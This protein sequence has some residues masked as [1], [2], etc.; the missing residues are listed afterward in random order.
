[1]LPPGYTVLG[2]LDD[3]PSGPVTVAR[4][5]HGGPA[6]AV[7][8]LPSPGDPALAERLGLLLDLRHPGAAT[9]LDW[10]LADDGLT[11]VSELL[12]AVPLRAL[13]ERSGLLPA[14]AAMV[15]LQDSLVAIAA[16]N[17]AGLP[18]GDHRPE[19]VVLTRRG[20]VRLLEVGVTTAATAPY[21]APEIWEGG[22]AS[23]A[24]D[25]YA[26][27]ALLVECLS[28]SPPHGGPEAEDRLREGHLHGPVPV[29]R[30]PEAL[31]D[32][33]RHGLA[34]EPQAR[35]G[36][37]R[38]LL[39]ELAAA[40]G[41][42]YGSGW[43]RR[44]REQLASGVRT[45]EFLFPP[46]RLL[47]PPPAAASP[48]APSLDRRRVAAAVAVT[49]ALLAVVVGGL[50]LRHGGTPPT[51]G[52][53]AGRSGGQSDERA[54][55]LIPG[56]SPS[57]SPSPTPTAPPAT[58]EPPAPTPS[59][60]PSPVPA[61]SAPLPLPL[62]PPVGTPVPTPTPAPAAL[63]ATNVRSLTFQPCTAGNGG[64]VCPFT[65]TFDWSDPQGTG[66]QIAWHLAV[67]LVSPATGCGTPASFSVPET[68]AVPGEQ[69]GAHSATITGSLTVSANPAGPGAHPPST[70]AASIDGTG[71]STGP[72]PFF[73]TSTC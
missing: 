48:G 26:A 12:D 16:A 5:P 46:P 6:V 49:A 33:V 15:V 19:T 71:A 41:G 13:L 4:P 20:D 32:L 8:T 40:A 11:L 58:P 70:A 2:T 23:P 62:P 50:A 54:P 3:G 18:R 45:L 67:Q 29:D 69:P 22:P 31:R 10:I 43:Q 44:G 55:L 42:A 63:T 14:E 66:G 47:A 73:G 56:A 65:V 35:C 34:R 7:V 21:L 57:P 25:V 59:P 37:A 24:S 1:M 61:T 52:S 30:V 72:A 60:A 68:T 17:D 38:L 9:L 39:I 64:F 51:T 27:T 28:G 53:S 36:D